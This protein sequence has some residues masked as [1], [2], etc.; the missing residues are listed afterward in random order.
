MK[1]SHVQVIAPTFN[2]A[3]S[4]HRIILKSNLPDFVKGLT[5]NVSQPNE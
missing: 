5:R 4:H 1:A 2:H 3:H